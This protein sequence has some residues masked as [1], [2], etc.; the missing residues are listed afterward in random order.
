MARVARPLSPELSRSYVSPINIANS[1][2]AAQLAQHG[3]QR[4]S[5]MDLPIL[6]KPCLLYGCVPRVF[7]PSLCFEPP[8]Q[9]KKKR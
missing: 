9:K 3:I 7:R 1:V 2:L 8:P 5:S 4:C 6:C